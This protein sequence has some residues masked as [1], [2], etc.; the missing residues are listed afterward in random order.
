[1]KRGSGS[2][3]KNQGAT[4][5][6]PFPRSGCY[7][8]TELKIGNAKLSCTLEAPWLEVLFHCIHLAYQT[9]K[10]IDRTIAMSIKLQIPLTEEILS[11]I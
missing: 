4:Q 11:Q 7:L 10:L 1:M 2:E 6:A 5:I 3:L 8:L 9:S